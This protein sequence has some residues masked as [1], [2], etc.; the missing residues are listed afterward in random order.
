MELPP[1]SS[2]FLKAPLGLYFLWSLVSNKV[3]GYPGES[4]RILCSLTPQHWGISLHYC[5]GVRNESSCP[6]ILEGHPS[7]VS[8]MLGRNGSLWSSWLASAGQVSR[9]ESK[10]GLSLLARA[11]TCTLEVKA[12]HSSCWDV[13]FPLLFFF[14]FSFSAYWGLIPGALLP[15]T[16]ILRPYFLR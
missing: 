7:F 11:R 9:S 14:F 8:L 2:S 12:R 13:D 3:V 1:K 4:F 5:S 6:F 16:Y 15:P 10:K